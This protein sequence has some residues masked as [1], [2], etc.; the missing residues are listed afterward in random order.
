MAS[1]VKSRGVV[2][3]ALICDELFSIPAPIL[4]AC[5]FDVQI[6]SRKLK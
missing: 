1:N 3:R 5:S 6:F 2:K 4:R